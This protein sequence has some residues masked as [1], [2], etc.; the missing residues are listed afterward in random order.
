MNGVRSPTAS[1]AP[2]T[3]NAARR[4]WRTESDALDAPTIADLSDSTV[5][6]MA[7]DELVRMICAA[8]LP[9]PAGYGPDRLGL[10]D[11]RTLQRLAF[12]ARRAC[13]NR[14]A[15]LGCSCGHDQP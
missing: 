1:G 13:R 11:Q 15:I 9:L 4:S 10:Q 6:A 8:D 3:E 5:V 2:H 14:V 7:R 12:L